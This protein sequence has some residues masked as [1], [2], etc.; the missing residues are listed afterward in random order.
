[1]KIRIGF[2]SNSSSASFVLK[3]R[4]LS[5]FQEEAVIDHL[6]CSIG[7]LRW[8]NDRHYN[9]KWSI[10]V[11]DKTIEGYTSTDNF[12]MSEF[13]D[14]IGIPGSEYEMEDDS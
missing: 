14:A 10:D 5:K 13:F 6:D 1:M 11:N 8:T 3:R 9:W 2:V 12:P 7:L 4:R